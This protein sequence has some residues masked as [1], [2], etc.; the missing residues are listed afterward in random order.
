[1]KK[2]IIISILV[3]LFLLTG[4]AFAASEWDF[5]YSY[6]NPN[7]PEAK[8]YITHQSNVNVRHESPVYYWCPAGP[9]TG[10]II[11]EFDFGEKTDKAYLLAK[12]PTFHWG[13]GQGHNYLYGST[14]G[15]TW[16]QLLDVTPPAYAHANPG[17]YNGNLPDE[18]IGVDKL[19]LKFVLST[20]ATSSGVWQNVA[21]FSRWDESYPNSTSFALNVAYQPVPVPAAVWLLGSGLL[22]LAGLRKKFCK[23]MN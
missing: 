4:N 5:S 20:T 19:F 15:D 17:V 10:E 13:Y 9:G 23:K 16:L 6:G 7:T 14:D 18:L 2:K 22:G 3:G 21:Q 11:M 12:M 8:T 1:M